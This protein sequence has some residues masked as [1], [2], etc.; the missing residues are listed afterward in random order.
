MRSAKPCVLTAV[1]VTLALALPSCS[2][3]TAKAPAAQAPQKVDVVPVKSEVMSSELTLQGQL[4]PYQSVDIY[5]KVAGFISAVP[6][7]RGSRVHAGDVLVRIT[8]PE[9]LAQ[10]GQA[11]SAVSAA[12]AQLAAVRA[13]LNSDAATAGH[14]ATAARTP[15]VVAENDVNIAQQ[16]VA[17]DRAQVAAASDNVSSARGGLRNVDQLA[18]YLT[19]RAPFAGVVTERDLDPGALVGPSQQTGG[20]PILRLA[21]LGR[22]RLAV[23]VPEEA[24]QG[25]TI[26]RSVKFTLPGAP[27]QTFSAPIARTSGALDP[28]NRTMMAELDVTNAGV[29]ATPG[30]FATVKWPMQRSYPTLQVPTT[31]VTNDQQQQF[32]VRVTGGKAEWVNVTTGM[33][34]DGNIEVFGKLNTGDLILLRGTD[35]VRDGSRVTA[36]RA[37]K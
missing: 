12:Q 36:V 32:V 1:C 20:K 28:R 5:P 16:T 30:G 18:S 34:K 19:I 23:P 24:A 26:G 10:R 27:G 13:R 4:N 15:G 2:D 8:A 21:A 11:A 22:L 17:A 9:L 3:E 14:L 7:D 6:V 33:T 25:V 31:S 37:K 29:V 35:A